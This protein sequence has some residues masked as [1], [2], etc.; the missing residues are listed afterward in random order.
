MTELKDRTRSASW[1]AGQ[2]T[3]TTRTRK[4][5]ELSRR[6]ADVFAEAEQEPVTLTRRDGGSMVLMSAARAE[7]IQHLLQLAARFTNASLRMDVFTPDVL[8]DVFPW[9]RALSERGRIECANE[10]REAAIASF[11]TSQSRLL[12]EAL[13]SW[14]GTAEALAAGLNVDD[15]EYLDEVVPVG[16]P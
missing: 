7:E 2:D 12:D 5:S 6:P 1:R 10:L 15:I 13:I 8:V 4:S 14:E 11:A 9:M 16:R 3:S